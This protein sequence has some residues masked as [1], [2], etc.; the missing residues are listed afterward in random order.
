MCIYAAYS[1]IYTVV[2]GSD[3]DEVMNTLQAFHA[4]GTFERSLNVTVVALIP[5]KAGASV[6]K[7]FCLI[8]WEC[9]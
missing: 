6:V 5:I 2:L 8:S 1:L 7:D 3:Q 9:L 4:H